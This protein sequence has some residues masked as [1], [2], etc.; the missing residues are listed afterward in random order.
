M[1]MKRAQISAAVTSYERRS[2]EVV[3]SGVISKIRRRSTLRQTGIALGG[4]WPAIDVLHTNYH[5]KP[6][7]PIGAHYDT[8]SI[9]ITSIRLNSSQIMD[10]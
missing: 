9:Q 8:K 7:P 10:R 3:V 2:P 1:E 4:A 6:D 5:H